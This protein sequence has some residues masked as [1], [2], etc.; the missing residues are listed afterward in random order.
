MRQPLF[1]HK[2][3]IR[4]TLLAV[5]LYL[6]LAIAA[7]DY[8]AGIMFFVSN[9]TWP[10]DVTFKTWPDAWTMYASNP[11]QRKKLQFSAG[12]GLLLMLGLPAFW[13]LCRLNRGRPLHGAA[14]F[15]RTEEIRAAG[16]FGDHGIV[17]GKVQDRYLI[18]GGQEFV[19]LAAPTRSGKGVSVVLPNL[20]HYPDS[21]VVLDIKLENFAYTSAFR[22]AHGQ[23]VYLFNPFGHDQ[24]THRWN[25]LDG[26]SRDPFRRVGDLLAIAHVLY[27]SEHVKEAFWNESA[28]NLFLGLTLYL[29]DTPS[30]PCTFGE[31][32]RQA[33][34]QG[35]PIRTYLQGLIDA[36][37]GGPDRLS[38]D[39]LAALH[40]FCATSD[41]TMAGIL[42][43]FTAPLTIFSHPLVDAA[44]SATDIDVTAV[45]SRRMSI[46]VGIPPNRLSE[47][48][49]LVN[50]FFSQL[51]QQNTIELPG[52]R[53]ELKYQCLLILD[54]F[55]SI[56]RVDILAKSVGFIA[57]YN[58]RLLPII[59]SLSQLE[60]IYGEKD[61]RTFATNHACQVLFAPREQKDAQAYSQMLGTYTAEVISTGSSAPRVW[62]AAQNGTITSHVSEQARPL[63]LPQELKD[64][65]DDHA[66]IN[67]VKIKPILCEKARFYTEDIFVDRLKA[68]SPSLAALGKKRPTAAQWEA[69]AFIK[70]ELSVPIPRLDLALH[71][72]K[73]E[74]RTRPL[75]VDEPIDLSRL[76]I[77]RTKLP[78]KI[79]E[80]S[81]TSEDIS[82][83]VDAFFEQLDW[84]H[85][86]VSSPITSTES[87]SNR[88]EVA[89]ISS[90]RTAIGFDLSVLDHQ[91]VPS[92]ERGR[93]V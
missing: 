60:S 13:W 34:G 48:A 54:E 93:D 53:P 67:L 72:A 15:A 68:I 63:M 57:G 88:S 5:L 7:A 28:R 55:P 38:E 4:I 75:K 73:V 71:T 91:S 84:S 52:N 25:P 61:A 31:L 59:Q 17:L 81:P 47:A 77:D 8:L 12:C 74:G 50:L 79:E 21:V 85:P 2:R 39:C 58:L 24:R 78:A 83:M 27:P 33:S 3:S 10:D 41:N 32:L 56:G 90:S 66:I 64:L 43:T 92:D 26:V 46:Y 51:I 19:L 37:A 35:Q 45:R 65:G 40:R 23:A 49:L 80:G 87:I 6:P 69:A 1:A 30:R 9:K 86:A 16:L 18:Y 14:R 22:A 82:R 42:A 11:V 44:T 20:L 89:D 62:G 76:A 36:R 70:K 29:L